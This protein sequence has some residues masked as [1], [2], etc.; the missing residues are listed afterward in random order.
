MR[1]ELPR[2][3]LLLAV[4]LRGFA[5]LPRSSPAGDRNAATGLPNYTGLGMGFCD[6][7]LILHSFNISFNL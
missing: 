1:W 2:P 6:N 5:G 7:H 4:R 3:R